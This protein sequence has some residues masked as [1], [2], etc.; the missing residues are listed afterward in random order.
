MATKTK[1]GPKRAAK[2]AKKTAA[3]KPAQRKVEAAGGRTVM[4]PTVVS[5]TTSFAQFTDPAGNVIGLFK[6]MGGAD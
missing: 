2:A 5:P 3:R 6:G 1:K 4:P